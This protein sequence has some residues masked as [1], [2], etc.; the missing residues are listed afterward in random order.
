MAVRRKTL[1]PKNLP[2]EAP[3]ALM[4]VNIGADVTADY[5]VTD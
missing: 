3:S 1:G 5:G 2:V 4:Q